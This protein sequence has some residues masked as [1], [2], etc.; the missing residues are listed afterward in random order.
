MSHTPES[1]KIEGIEK[2]KQLYKVRVG[3]YKS[4]ES[5]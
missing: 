3:D 5:L 2:K 1:Y 4:V